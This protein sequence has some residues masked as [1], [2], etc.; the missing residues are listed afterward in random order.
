MDWKG[1]GKEERMCKAEHDQSDRHSN[2][3]KSDWSCKV[4]NEGMMD[5][6]DGFSELIKFKL[7][8]LWSRTS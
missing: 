5:S 6:T 3:W 2:N 8:S 4:N 1:E 7:Q